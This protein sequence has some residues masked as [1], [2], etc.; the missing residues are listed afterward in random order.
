M[1]IW[2]IKLSYKLV[3]LH[4]RLLESL[5][6]KFSTANISETRRAMIFS[7]AAM[8]SATLNWVDSDILAQETQKC[9]AVLSIQRLRTRID[10]PFGTSWH[11]A[12]G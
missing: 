6:N 8:D 11:A 7:K 1:V 3:D 12:V 5:N 9:D 10:I 4:A 2:A